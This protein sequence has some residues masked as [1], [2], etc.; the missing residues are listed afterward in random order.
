M[1]HS[2]KFTFAHGRSGFTTFS[3]GDASGRFEWEMLIG[4]VSMVIYAN[5]CFW[6]KPSE[7]RIASDDIR[8][9]VQE[10]STESDLTVEIQ[11]AEGCETVWP[12]NAARLRGDRAFYD[13]LGEE[14]QNTKCRQPDC[15][16]GTIP[17]SVY[18]RPHHF[19]S[20]LDRPC[21]FDD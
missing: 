12:N 14:R 17:Q 13:R 4:D 5:S 2:K 21:P 3:E 19:E 9:L 6:I 16:R 15:P 10:F 18:C 11:F 1:M 20:M 8:R 7:V